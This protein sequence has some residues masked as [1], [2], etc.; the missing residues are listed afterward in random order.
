MRGS[1][2]ETVEDESTA[3]ADEMSTKQALAENDKELKSGKYVCEIQIQR[4][5]TKGSL[6]GH[7]N[8]FRTSDYVKEAQ[9][10]LNNQNVS[11]EFKKKTISLIKR[12]R[13]FDEGPGS[14]ISPTPYGR[15]VEANQEEPLNL[16][17]KMRGHCSIYPDELRA[18][19]MSYKADL[20]NLLNDLNNLNINDEKITKEQKEKVI[21]IINEKGNITPK[22]LA[23]LLGTDLCDITGFR[24]NKKNEPILTEFKGYKEIRKSLSDV[25]MADD[26][27]VQQH[28]N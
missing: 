2:L 12:R 14:F 15:Y 20:F 4:L 25:K 28:R 19:R 22:N 8:N 3:T 11:D 13:R 1:S 23:K 5:S 24:L 10:I 17:E 26:H 9:K 21:E 18:P 6:R 27:V 16:I 7:V